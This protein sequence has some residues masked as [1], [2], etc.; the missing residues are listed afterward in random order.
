VLG[1]I[2]GFLSRR[3][4]YP[5]IL[6]IR[7]DYLSLHG[8]NEEALI[9]YDE[10]IASYSANPKF[11]CYEHESDYL[12]NGDQYYCGRGDVLVKMGRYEDALD[13]YTRCLGY[14][15]AY[16]SYVCGRI[17]NVYLELNNKEEA[18]K[19]QQGPPTLEQLRR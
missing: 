1:E 2:D 6:Q 3:P 4:R 7:A 15:D 11:Y 8:L 16:D 12:S 19:W 18:A 5:N 14:S 9:D 10:C 17:A 13:D